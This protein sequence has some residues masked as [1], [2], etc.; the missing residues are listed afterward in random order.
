MQRWSSARRG[1][2]VGVA[3]GALV[4]GP[5]LA[6]NQFGFET[7][8]DA[9]C[10][11]ELGRVEVDID[12]YGAFGT[13]V[14]ISG[15]Q[16]YDPA[17]DAPD[18]GLV[19]TVFESMPFLCMEDAGGSRGSWLEAGA[20]NVPVR[21]QLVDG[22]VETVFEIEGLEVQG[23]FFLNCTQMEQCYTFTNVSDVDLPIVSITPYIDG[24]LYFNGG[25]GNDYGG[26]S[27]GAPK[28][29][30]EFDEGDNPEEPTTFL[31]LHGLAG[32]DQFL[33]SWEIGEYSE[34]RS[35]IMDMDFGCTILAN[36]INEGGVN[37]DRDGDLITD[38][39][40]DVTLALRFDVG[41]LAPGESSPAV[42]YAVQ[43]GYGRP[44]SD[45]D[46]DEI[47]LPDDNCP[48]VPNPDQMDED[49]D[50]VG[51]AC[52]NC[53]K[54]INPDQV[55]QDGDGAGDACDRV[56]CTPDGQPEV[57]DGQDNDCDGLVDVFGDGTSTVAPGE[58]A[59]G[60]NAACALGHWA[61]SLG[62]TRCLPDV[63]PDDEIC[64]RVDNDCDG[65][66]DEEVRNAC[67]GCGP[68]PDETCNG[69]DDDCDGGVD[70]LARCPGEDVCYQGQCLPPCRDNECGE[71]AF[72]AD[73]ACVPWCTV[74]ACAE[75]ETCTA[76][77]CTDPCAGVQ[78][79]DGEACAD[80]VCGLNHCIHTGC[81]AHQRCTPD[82][83][84]AD[85]CWQVDCGANSFCRDG[86]CIFSCAEVT[87]AA[88]SACFDG[89]CQGTGCEPLGCDAEHPI[90]EMGT[91]V[92]DPCK[93]M[94]CGPAEICYRGACQ[95]DPCQG[96]RC[97]RLERCAV[98]DG[99][100]QC[101][102]D[103]APA[104]EAPVG[105]TSGA[106]GAGGEA[107]GGG[108][109]PTGG[110]GGTPAPSGGA[111]PPV[112][113]T[114]TGGSDQTNPVVDDPDAGNPGASGGGG[115]GGGCHVARRVGGSD[116]LAGL[117]LPFML[118][119]LRRRRRALSPRNG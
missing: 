119:A 13:S 76:Q 33:T 99:T 55:D 95:A 112:G 5:A 8:A 30:W 96:I 41:P 104:P 22:H 68:L 78:C 69:I 24:D 116:A 106:G 36:N 44:C 14:D 48:T 1:L 105:G 71:D 66:V 74:D 88:A 90:C 20:A 19:N 81:P 9:D 61:C 35:R 32:A 72:C 28:T 85:P 17:L 80:G 83:C 70:E 118:A 3:V 6:Q 98:T 49:L 58:C 56:I 92:E 107:N 11:A 21:A 103:W 62:R 15:R 91:C 89:V 63:T 109:E 79:A 10:E 23:N 34:Q 38:D 2:Q 29:L 47:C 60:L 4:G 114:T 82:G 45:E 97:P 57:C 100:A 50:G 117:A 27:V 111:M 101:V 53:P 43:W 31:G 110:A 115:G 86:A 94:T 51:D 108:Q 67:G 54:I 52:D 18:Q 39:G 113:G 65:R 59:T 40:Y 26:T 84:A 12:P 64:D 42:C 87:C 73:G 25:L 102:A 93:G 7:P 16:G 46:L 37:A 75:G 77:G